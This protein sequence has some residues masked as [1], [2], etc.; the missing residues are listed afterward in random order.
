MDDIQKP[1]RE[2]MKQRHT[3]CSESYKKER[4][5]ET[6]RH[7]QKSEGLEIWRMNSFCEL[8]R[9][10]ASIKSIYEHFHK[11]A[12]THSFMSNRFL[13]LSLHVFISLIKLNHLRS[14]F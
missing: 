13:T 2:H 9:S 6:R 10:T 3:Q 14:V 5:W 8:A 1:E 12:K 4:I 7:R 11:F